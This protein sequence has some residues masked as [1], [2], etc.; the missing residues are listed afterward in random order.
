MARP[1]LVAADPDLLD[2]LLRLCGAAGTPPVVATDPIALA[3]AWPA[4]S[5]VLLGADGV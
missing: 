3:R 5:V 1:L 4:A 2:E